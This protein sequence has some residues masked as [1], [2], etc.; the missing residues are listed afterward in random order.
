MKNVFGRF[1]REL[2]NSDWAT[3][4]RYND[5]WCYIYGEN[6]EKISFGFGKM[7]PKPSQSPCFAMNHPMLR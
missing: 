2:W 5:S 1:L 7:K 6:I 4:I 3:C